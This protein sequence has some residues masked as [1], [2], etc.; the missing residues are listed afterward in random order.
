MMNDIFDKMDS[1]D[2]DDFF[3]NEYPHCVDN[4]SHIY[5][6]DFDW[7]LSDS[8]INSII[9]TLAECTKDENI[10]TVCI[11]RNEESNKVHLYVKIIC[12]ENAKIGVM[13]KWHVG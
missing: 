4:V 12:E 5:Y 8:A 9:E 1:V 3:L 2:D 6:L 10:P 7:N 11:A 13:T